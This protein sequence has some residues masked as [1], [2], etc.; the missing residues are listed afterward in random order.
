MTKAVA[1]STSAASD[2]TGSSTGVT[3]VT[4]TAPGS[5]VVSSQEI[6]SSQTSKRSLLQY[7]CVPSSLLLFHMMGWKFLLKSGHRH[8]DTQQRT[9]DSWKLSSYCN[10]NSHLDRHTEEWSGFGKTR[11]LGPEKYR[12][13]CWN[14]RHVVLYVMAERCAITWPNLYISTHKDR[15]E[16]KGILAAYVYT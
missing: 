3:A 12:H 13:L 9:F 7:P 15:P 5:T 10:N 11:R 2:A 6:V 1:S 16:A 8:R 4:V 14:D